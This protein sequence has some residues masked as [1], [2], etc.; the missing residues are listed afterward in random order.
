M[1]LRG[2]NYYYIV[3]M[4]N[5]QKIQYDVA[6][7]YNTVVQ[8]IGKVGTHEANR[9]VQR[10]HR[11]MMEPNETLIQ[12]ISRLQYM[13]ERAAEIIKG[14]GDPDF[15]FSSTAIQGIIIENAI[16]HPVYQEHMMKLMRDKPNL[17]LGEM[18]KELKGWLDQLDDLKPAATRRSQE[19]RIAPKKA[20]AN[21]TETSV[22]KGCNWWKRNGHCKYGDQCHFTHEA[23]NK[24]PHLR[25]GAA[26]QR[27]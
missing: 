26:K 14:N 5:N 19:K 22:G 15:S 10:V 16:Q 2:G 8:L 3:T 27:Q 7:L 13:A 4:Y 12:F 1:C 20:S 11:A 6:G 24:G 9:R 23:K 21:L 18:L 25:Q 17:S